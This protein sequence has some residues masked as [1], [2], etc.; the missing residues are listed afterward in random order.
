MLQIITNSYVN[1]A[2]ADRLEAGAPFSFT[3]K[4]KKPLSHEKRPFIIIGD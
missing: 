4:I 3:L 2:P 1:E